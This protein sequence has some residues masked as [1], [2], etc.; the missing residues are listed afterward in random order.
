[1]ANKQQKG[2]CQPVR[3]N[4][5]A[6]FSKSPLRENFTSQT[7][8]SGVNPE[9]ATNLYYRMKVDWKILMKYD[10]PFQLISSQQ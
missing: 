9:V 8:T 6:A 10:M 5:L 1:M 7:F 3:S 4:A 2:T